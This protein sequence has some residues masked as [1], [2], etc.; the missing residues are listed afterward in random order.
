MRM[1]KDKKIS[2]SSSRYA[3][4]PL[5][6][7]KRTPPHGAAATGVLKYRYEHIYIGLVHS[8]RKTAVLQVQATNNDLP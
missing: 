8:A 2:V 4:Q 6:A 7:S 3:P 5:T 1:K